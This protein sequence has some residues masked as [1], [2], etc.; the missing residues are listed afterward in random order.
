MLIQN[1]HIPHGWANGTIALVDYIDE[2]FICLKKFRNAHDDEPEEQIYWIQ[3]IIRQVPS[4]GYTRTQFPVV[5]A[6]ASTIH[7]A[8]STSIDCV[9]IHL[10]TRSPMISFMCQCLE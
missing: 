2:E 5:P 3:R 1:V 10:E 8:Q 6:F 9:A 4:T 7:K